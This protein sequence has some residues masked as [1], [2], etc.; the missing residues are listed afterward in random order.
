M[1]Q[2]ECKELCRSHITKG[3]VSYVKEFELDPERK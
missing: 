2:N 3:L 1:M